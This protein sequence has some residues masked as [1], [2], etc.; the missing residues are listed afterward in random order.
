M[1]GGVQ[2]CQQF[3]GDRRCSGLSMIHKKNF[4]RKRG[5]MSQKKPMRA[6]GNTWDKKKIKIIDWGKKRSPSPFI[7]VGSATGGEEKRK[8]KEKNCRRGVKRS[9][10]KHR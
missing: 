5:G 8:V 7:Q 4:A 10:R 6:G 2:V 1:G 3:T 9:F